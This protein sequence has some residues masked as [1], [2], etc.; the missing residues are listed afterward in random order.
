MYLFSD[1]L[2]LELLYF[3][4]VGNDIYL[5][6]RIRPRRK[7]YKSPFPLF[8]PGKCILSFKFLCR[9]RIYYVG[10]KNRVQ[11]FYLGFFEFNHPSNLL[12]RSRNMTLGRSLSKLNSLSAMRITRPIGASLNMPHVKES[13]DPPILSPTIGCSYHS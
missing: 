9:L 11:Y 2:C 4:D 13:V 3:M 12:C 10:I 8:S 6:N 7:S 1:W 5:L